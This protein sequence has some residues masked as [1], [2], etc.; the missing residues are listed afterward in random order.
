MNSAVSFSD[1]M[2][3]AWPLMTIW[4]GV[5]F[6][7]AIWGPHP[8]LILTV[9]IGISLGMFALGPYAAAAIYFMRLH[10]FLGGHLRW[11]LCLVL[12]L[13]AVFLLDHFLHWAQLQIILAGITASVG[14]ILGHDATLA[15][16]R[17]EKCPGC[18]ARLLHGGSASPL[19]GAGRPRRLLQ[20][21]LRYGRL[22]LRRSVR[23][24]WLSPYQNSLRIT[25][26]A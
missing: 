3:N 1:R 23:V 5:G 16:A 15:V 20:P 11:P 17:A 21:G 10:R 18:Q 14:T 4:F 9:A 8:K 22:Q 12:A 25:S 2:W 6:A 13:S 26:V 19:R 24:A 7:I